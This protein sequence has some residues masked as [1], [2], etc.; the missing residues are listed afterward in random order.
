MFFNNLKNK[1]NKKY[2]KIYNVIIT[3]FVLIFF[4]QYEIHRCNSLDKTMLK[5]KQFENSYSKS[6]VNNFF[7]KTD[8]E[9][10]IK[11]REI[12]E[13]NILIDHYIY[14]GNEEPDISVIITVYNQA[15]CFYKVLRSVQ[16]QSL[17]N[18]EI[19]IIDDCS[20]DNTTEVIENY[21]KEDKRIKYL[22]NESNNGKIKSRSDGVRMAKGKYITIID[23]DDALSHENILFNS[24][25]IA[26]MANLD[27]VEFRYGFFE[28]HKLIQLNFNLNNIKNLKNRII[29]QPE[30][31]FKFVDLVE[32][33]SI[34]GF[35]NRCIW[36]KLIKNDV[37][38]KVVEFIGP[39][40]T[41]DYLLDYEDTIM[42]VAL[43]RVAKSYY[44]MQEL[45]YYKSKG[46]CENPFP[47]LEN[48][49][50]KSKNFL[51]NSEL[52]S[53]KYLN[54]LLDISK[55]SEIE[56]KLI[57]KELMALDH[58]KKLNRKINKNFSYVYSIINRINESSFYLNN[59]R[60]KINKIKSKLLKK[61]S[62]IKA[63]MNHINNYF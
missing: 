19:I 49:K 7:M 59:H 46:E 25:T 36:G 42:V 4:H 50:C 1:E 9:E 13:N 41:E 35:S 32:G 60:K 20:L 30:L 44:Y 26:N 17:K 5:I 18:I 47:I 51:I 62:I 11:Y 52:D 3:I 58:Y 63:K 56:N 24:L 34:N 27:V 54:F 16:N 38:R 48:K 55:N 40:Y 53:I 39:K 2:K 29:Y 45:G 31:T 37:F 23:G 14:Q 33:D 15:N 61:E 28:K 21:M 8:I 12:N 22:K 6:F 57:Y 43:F 10:S